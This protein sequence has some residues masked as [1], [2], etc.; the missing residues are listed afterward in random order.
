[1][2]QD[3]NSGDEMVVTILKKYDPTVAKKT[4]LFDE[5]TA[6]IEHNAVECGYNKILQTGKTLR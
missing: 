5:Y 6:I 1:M 3:Y 2:Q 4:M